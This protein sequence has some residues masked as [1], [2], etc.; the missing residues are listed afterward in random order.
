MKWKALCGSLWP[1]LGRHCTR[2]FT[3]VVWCGVLWSLI[4]E[5]AFPRR[6]I[7]QRRESAT[8][9]CLLLENQSMIQ[10]DR[11]EGNW[12][13]RSIVTVTEVSVDENEHKTYTLLVIQVDADCQNI[14]EV[15]RVV[16]DVQGN[17]T[18]PILTMNNSTVSIDAEAAFADNEDEITSLLQFPDGHIF[19]LAV[20]LIFASICGFIAKLIYFPPLFGMII[21]GFLLRNV[22]H[23]DFAQ[24][25][26]P[27]WSST[28]RNVALV[29]VLIRGGLSL[30]PEQLKRLKLAV[31]LLAFGPCVV[32]GAVDGIVGT[33]YLKLPWQWAFMLG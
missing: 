30:N 13:S 16:V 8:Q 33:F 10:L 1:S 25:I 20:L 14:L 17:D 5:E 31:L 26:S 7:E 12:S 22:P 9:P 18:V 6:Y 23:I 15:N 21:A 3:V 2:V 19:G 32:E 24:D 4:G 27:I 28:I 11:K 29:I